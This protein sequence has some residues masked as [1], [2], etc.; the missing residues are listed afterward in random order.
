M[1]NKKDTQ[2][3]DNRGAFKLA[4]LILISLVLALLLSQLVMAAPFGDAMRSL[5]DRVSGYFNDYAS[6]DNP[7]VIDFLVFAVI[8]FTMCWVGFSAVFKEAK[9]ANI[10]LS[11]ALGLALS[12]ALV[13]GGKF[14]LKK[15]L[16]FAA[17][18]LFILLIIGIYAL[19]TKFVFKGE[20]T[21]KKILAIFIAILVSI[22][23]LAVAWSFIC[24]NNRCENN[25]F[26]KKMF[27]SESLLG[28][29]FSGVGD[30]FGEG[31]AATPSTSAA[32]GAAAPG[33]EVAVCGNGKVELSEVCDSTAK[34]TG[35]S[36]KQVCDI[37]CTRCVDKSTTEL[38]MDTMGENWGKYFILVPVLVILLIV[39]LKYRK[40]MRERWLGF[41]ERRRHKREI[42]ALS[43][44]LRDAQHN[45]KRVIE[46]FREL[47]NSMKREK[48]IF[49][50]ERH[51]VSQIIGDVKETIGD[52]ISFVKGA[53]IGN[54]SNID[55]Q[56]NKLIGLNNQERH[57]I[58]DTDGIIPNMQQQ[59]SKIG[60]MG[61]EMKDA[62]NALDKVD[63]YFSD[64]A[65]L[66]ETFKQHKDSFREAGVI[67]KMKKRLEDNEKEFDSFAKECKNMIDTLN[68]MSN[69]HI[70]G[71][72]C[73][74]NI[75][76]P[77]ILSHI[78]GIRENAIR[79]NRIFVWKVE[80]I[81]HFADTLQEV[82][83]EM[84]S[85]HQQEL[86]NL[87]RY[88]DNAEQARV[89]G[90][91][92]RAI[93]LAAH[94]VENAEVMKVTGLTATQVTELNNMTSA[95]LQTIKLS[96][97]QLFPSMVT[98]IQEELNSTRPDKF[99][100]L[101]Q[102]VDKVSIIGFTEAAHR[103]AL[104]PELH[105]HWERMQKLKMLCDIW[106]AGL[107]ARTSVY[108]SLGLTP[109]P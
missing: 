45:E 49:D 99:D 12:V 75:D 21:G 42:T 102:F 17:V 43:R 89:S 93:Y 60:S 9:P 32:P 58:I 101:R 84:A 65:D 59:A 22:A 107:A 97:P 2:M 103:Q 7:R 38:V 11:V 44:L 28:G 105:D 19:L 39:L 85:L 100:K 47:C 77:T 80:A 109:P 30:I 6:D 48:A 73:A 50:N 71:I 95:A 1:K 41:R 96:L 91:F 90:N 98:K 92:D 94:V 14:T 87:V 27:G 5:G 72:I 36:N 26:L 66:L 69:T 54:H 53:V 40:P 104:E 56:V 86:D 16:P 57:W 8:F 76:Y 79:L 23:I 52:E 10:A 83:E 78:R 4:S 13:Y 82:K 37:G 3:L 108:T 35:C 51:I 62:I 33:A 68:T 81:R 63:E 18:L 34:E 64:H 88:K 25:A 61:K 24:D 70:Q 74:G 15:L 20:S 46:N 55:M 29:V 67:D 31:A 106:Q